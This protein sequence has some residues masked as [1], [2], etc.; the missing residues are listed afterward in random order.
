M[1][2]SAG[3]QQNSATRETRGV[4]GKKKNLGQNQQANSLEEETAVR[5]LGRSSLVSWVSEMVTGQLEQPA[6]DRQVHEQHCPLRSRPEYIDMLLVN[7]S[8]IFAA[9]VL[10]DAHAAVAASA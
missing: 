6:G 9:R 2:S 7:G 10:H 3:G 5:P 8:I 4:S 1:T